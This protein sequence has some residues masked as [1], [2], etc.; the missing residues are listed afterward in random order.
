VK[1]DQLEPATTGLSP[2]R[3]REAEFAD[4]PKI[5]ELESTFFDDSLPP[6]ARRGLFEDNPLWPRLRD[7][8]PIGWVLEDGDGRIVGSVNNIPSAYRFE[9][10]ELICGNGH[11]W[12]VL[13]QYRSYAAMLMDEYFL[14]DGTDLIVSAKVG[15][16]A[17]PVWSAYAHRV[18]VGDWA[19]AAY[20]ITRYPGFARSA[21]G[22]KHVPLAWALALPVAAGLRL[23]DATTRRTLPDGP[24]SVE[25]GELD[26][27]DTRFDAF[28]RELSARN[29]HLLLGVRDAAAQRWHYA[30]PRRAGRVWVLGAERAGLLRAY[31]VLKQHLR[32]GGV[33]S[34]KLIDYQTLDDDTDLL[35]G[36][37]RLAMRRSAAENCHF[38]EHHGCGLPKMAAFD[39]F[40]AYRAT[41]PTWSFYYRADDPALEGRL[42]DPAVWDPSEYDGDSSYK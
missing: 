33:R 3:L 15:A 22:R 39:T 14:Q 25:F 18:P 20:A 27:F 7:T 10:E 1:R 32:P 11:C 12:A 35:P 41:K 8:W 5:Y 24:P 42:A 17:A 6:A 30:V 34:M 29:P 40:A 26:G 2:P 36:L 38:L 21:L 9:G 16:D 31:C 13:D 23:K 4:Y 37:L 19:S 28:W